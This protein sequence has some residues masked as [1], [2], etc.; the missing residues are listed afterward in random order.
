[1]I[2]YRDGRVH[3]AGLSIPVILDARDKNGGQRQALAARL[4]Y[5]RIVRRRTR[6]RDHWCTQLVTNGLPP[7]KARHKL[8]HGEAGMD[9]GPSTIA[10][11]PAIYA[12]LRTFCPTVDDIGRELRLVE[13]AMD[14]SRRATNPDKDNP[15]GA[16]KKGARR[17]VRSSRYKQWRDEKAEAERRLGSERKGSHGEYIN[18]TLALGHVFKLEKLS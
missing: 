13:R 9:L 15:D 12:S 3:W 4:K 6:R 17:W 10:T 11:V 8:G 14:R 18:H 2:R 5:V 16:A 7:L 1:M